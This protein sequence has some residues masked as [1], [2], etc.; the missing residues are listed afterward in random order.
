ME[1]EYILS[2]MKHIKNKRIFEFNSEDILSDIKDICLELRDDG[3][4]IN[5][6]DIGP[7]K[8]NVNII[9]NKY[10]GS[11]EYKSISEVMERIKEYLG[12][13]FI[14]IEVIPY[15][16]P[17]QRRSLEWVSEYSYTLSSDIIAARIRFQ[18]LLDIN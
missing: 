6:G 16:T 5:L 3:Y 2:N 10:P 4:I 11:F 13:K 18:L 12:N 15:H 1:L 7:S 14:S 9:S 17:T 8:Y